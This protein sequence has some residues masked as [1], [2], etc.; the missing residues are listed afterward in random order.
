[1]AIV[2]ALGLEVLWPH[3]AHGVFWWHH[4][5]GF[6]IVYGFVGCLALMAGAQWLGR[7]WLERDV[8]SHCEEPPCQ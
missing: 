1:M 3:E 6:A 7:T 2:L 4:V 5:P 8:D